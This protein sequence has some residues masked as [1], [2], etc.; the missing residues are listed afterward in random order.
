MSKYYITFGEK[1][2]HD[3]GGYRY[4]FHTSAIIEGGNQFEARIIAF[5]IFGREWCGLYFD[6][7][8]FSK[9]IDLYLR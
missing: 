6:K 2:V 4:D 9:S 5:N 8:K 1:H 7:P 3:V